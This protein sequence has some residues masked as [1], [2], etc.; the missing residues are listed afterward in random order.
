MDL[1]YEG[2]SLEANIMLAEVQPILVPIPLKPH[3]PPLTTKTE[4]ALNLE[5]VSTIV[6]TSKLSWC[7]WR[8]DT[9]AGFIAVRNWDSATQRPSRN[10]ETHRTGVKPSVSRNARD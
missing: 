9:P 7:H 10:L 3:G 8:I 1:E 4:W 5:R 2:S 6:C